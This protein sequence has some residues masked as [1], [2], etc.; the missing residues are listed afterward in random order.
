MGEKLFGLITGPQEL[1]HFRQQREIPAASRLEKSPP[2][3][4]FGHFAGGIKE[5]PLAFTLGVHD[6][7]VSMVNAQN[8]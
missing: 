6:F 2:L 3:R 8:R 4:G 7:G 5:G 1:F